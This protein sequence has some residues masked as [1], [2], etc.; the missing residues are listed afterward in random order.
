MKYIPIHSKKHPGAVFVKRRAS[1]SDFVLKVYPDHEGAAAFILDAL[2][3]EVGRAVEGLLVIAE[4]AIERGD[5]SPQSCH[6]E[7]GRRVLSRLKVGA[8]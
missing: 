3:G 2:N 6:V 8:I 1:A 5:I 7:A 4:A